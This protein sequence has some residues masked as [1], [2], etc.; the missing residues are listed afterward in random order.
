MT[1][2]IDIGGGCMPLYSSKSLKINLVTKKE[3]TQSINS[4]PSPR[5]SKINPSLPRIFHHKS[6]NKASKR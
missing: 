1:T 5:D 6:K 2:M 3:T 4:L